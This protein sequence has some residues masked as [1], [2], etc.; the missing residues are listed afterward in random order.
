MQFI[1]AAEFHKLNSRCIESAHGDN[2]KNGPVGA[3]TLSAGVV[4]QGCM[5]SQV[6]L[7]SRL[8]CAD[9]VGAVT[10]AHLETMAPATR[11]MMPA[12][13]ETTMENAMKS[14]AR[15]LQIC[16]AAPNTVG[17]GHR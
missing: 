10:M 4:L 15:R 16:N 7:V 14:R 8:V 11:A 2:C 1:G 3:Y 13:S 5:M 6:T 9:A 12:T 17:S